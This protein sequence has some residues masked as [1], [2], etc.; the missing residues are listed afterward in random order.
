MFLN[1]IMLLLACCECLVSNAPGVH[2]GS[3]IY[4]K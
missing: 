4:L 3:T 1:G 2:I